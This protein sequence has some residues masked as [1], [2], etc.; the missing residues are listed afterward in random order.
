MTHYYSETG[1]KPTFSTNLP[2]T[3]SRPVTPI[4]EFQTLL[5]ENLGDTTLVG[6]G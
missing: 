2:K 1:D 6:P 4:G 3:I 5:L